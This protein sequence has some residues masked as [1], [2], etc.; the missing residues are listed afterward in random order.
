MNVDEQSSK[1]IK[2]THNSDDDAQ[3][4]IFRNETMSIQ[5]I[6]SDELT[7]PI[8]RTNVV[9]GQIGDTKQTSTIILEL[10]RMVPLNDLNHLKR[11][12]KNAV[13]LCS[14]AELAKFVEIN[15]K[16]IIERV[17]S[18]T[19]STEFPEWAEQFLADEQSKP[20]T[21]WLDSRQEL[22]R[23]AVEMYLT[24]R[25]VSTSMLEGLCK[26]LEIIEVAAKQPILHWQYVLAQKHWP[27]KF[28]QN[29]ILEKLF[30]NR[31]FDTK[32]TNFHLKMMALCKMLA[33]KLAR[34]A[35]GIAVDPRN[36]NIVA[37]GA[38]E[39]DRHPLMHC[40]MVLIDAVA[41]TQNGGA[42]N[43]RLVDA[44]DVTLTDLP[45]SDDNYRFSGVSRPVK[46]FILGQ[47]SD[48]TFGGEVVKTAGT[49]DLTDIP[50]SGDNLAKFGPYLCTGYDVYLLKEPCVMCSMALVHSRVRRIFFY[51]PTE[52]GGL[53]TLTKIHTIK[54]LNHHFDVFQ[55][56]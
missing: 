29:K 8:P 51:S 38:I 54:Q 18:I 16:R 7:Q 27:G 13:I 48:T 43:D 12:R 24:V 26:S 47:F 1:R 2:L 31:V 42:W 55:I 6:L 19:S 21:Q 50:D 49:I 14:R 46:E 9:I 17:Q 56:R 10:S 4:A 34:K 35:T 36:G 28:H 44:S 3:M 30:N 37:V 23:I 33:V 53:A 22:L 45:A 52:T 25:R 5:S 11:V 40:P 41:R 32:Q 20:T 39:I 15:S